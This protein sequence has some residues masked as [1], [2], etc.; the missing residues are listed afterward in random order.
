MKNMKQDKVLYTDGRDVVV[1]DSTLK[2]KNTSYRLNGITKLCFWTIRPHRWPAVFILLIGLV[3][4]VL[5]YLNILPADINMNNEDGYLSANTLALWVGAALI[6]IGILALMLSKER[7]AVRIGT[8]EG[9][10]NAV[11]SSKREY[12]SQIVDAIH[13][14]FD[15]GYK[16]PIVADAGK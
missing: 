4:A 16:D 5:G 1:T 11:V 7:Y 13:S 2:V 3:F 15:L 12:I 14:A 10:K 9:E 6:F 8:A